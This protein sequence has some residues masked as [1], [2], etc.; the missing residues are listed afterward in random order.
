MSCFMCLESRAQMQHL[1]TWVTVQGPAAHT[2]T[3]AMAQPPHAHAARAD[4]E[5]AAAT[6]LLLRVGELQQRGCHESAADLLLTLRRPSASLRPAVGEAAYMLARTSMRRVLN[7]RTLNPAAKA[8][9]ATCICGVGRQRG[10][11]MVASTLLLLLSSNTG[12]SLNPHTNPIFCQFATAQALRLLAVGSE[13]KA[14]ALLAA[15]GCCVRLPIVT[16]HA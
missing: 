5:L 2:W 10:C 1:L 11:S 9:V 16:L 14:A 7:L 4:P 3:R 6:Q 8:A 13:G 15:P 12:H